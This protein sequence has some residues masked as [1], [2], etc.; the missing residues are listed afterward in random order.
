MHLSGFGPENCAH[1]YVGDKEFSVGIG[2]T[3]NMGKL[4]Y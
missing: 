3:V 4:G 2:A 1:K